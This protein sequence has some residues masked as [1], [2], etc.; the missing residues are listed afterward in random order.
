MSKHLGSPYRSGRSRASSQKTNWVA[1]SVAARA[2]DRSAESAHRKFPDPP[3]PRNGSGFLSDPTLS[4]GRP[5][6]AFGCR[7]TNER[8][9]IHPKGK[10]LG[11]AISA[12]IVTLHVLIS[13]K[14]IPRYQVFLA[15][16]LACR[17]QRLEASM[18]KTGS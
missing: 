6:G 12:R 8:G 9:G 7:H 1:N 2:I 16:V 15:G 17:L 10:S 13:A 3:S 11:D 5:V 14:N 18:G 4:P